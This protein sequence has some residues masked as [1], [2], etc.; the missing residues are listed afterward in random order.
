MNTNRP[1]YVIVFTALITAGFTAAVMTVQDLA[2]DKIAANEAGRFGRALVDVLGVGES[3]DLSGKQVAEI[4]ETRIKFGFMV[5]DP[6]T[7]KEF[8]VIRAYGQDI[9]SAGL[10]DADVTGLAFRI[11]GKGFWAPISGL[12]ALSPDL[13][14][15]KGIVFLDHKETPGLGGRISEEWFVEQ[16]AGRDISRKVSGNKFICVS[17]DEPSAAGDPRYGRPVEAI[18]G[19]TQ[20]SMAVEKLVNENLAQFRRGMQR[21]LKRPT[22]AEGNK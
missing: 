12:I 14:Q 18:T 1:A 7:G 2:E 4:I 5:K 17:K 9:S 15:I 11:E 20:T 16:F 13:K 21:G 3:E 10:G 6:Q 19:A 22:E 8:E